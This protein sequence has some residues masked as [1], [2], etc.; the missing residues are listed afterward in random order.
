M[1]IKEHSKEDAIMSKKLSTILR[2]IP[3][4]LSLNDLQV[5]INENNLETVKNIL[6]L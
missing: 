6:E 1:L 5:N 4:D 3:L 2:N